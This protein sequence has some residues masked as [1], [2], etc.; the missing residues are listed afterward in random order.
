[1]KIW[2]FIKDYWLDALAMVVFGIFFIVPFIFI[3]LTAAKT[4]KEAALF[5]LT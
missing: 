4:S 3:F 2:K 5:E 1:M